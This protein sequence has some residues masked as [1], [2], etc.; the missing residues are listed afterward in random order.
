MRLRLI[1][2]GV[3]TAAFGWSA[4]F[5]RPTAPTP[6]TVP[7]NTEVGLEFEVR[8]A[9][10]SAIKVVMLDPAITVA[11]RYGKLVI[12]VTEIRRIEPGFRFPDGSEIKVEKAI[13]ALASPVFAERE[14]A[15]QALV[16][17]EQASDKRR[18]N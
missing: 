5:A 11:T 18:I 7:A 4:S 14:D 8:M 16:K 12:P 3:L 1:L 2:G 17:L 13:E 10:E 9:D 6:A 15:E